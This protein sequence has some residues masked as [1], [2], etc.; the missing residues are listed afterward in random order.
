MSREVLSVVG[1]AI[2]VAVLENA[3]IGGEGCEALVEGGGADAALGA[4][5]SKRQRLIGL[6]E[7]GHDAFV[8]RGWCGSYGLATIGDLQCESVASLCQL[9][10]ERFGR[11]GRAVLDR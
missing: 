5:L 2:A 10:R 6:G 9:D 4:Q 1:G 7:D 3:A 11:W 8:E